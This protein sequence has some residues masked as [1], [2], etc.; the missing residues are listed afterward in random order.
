MHAASLSLPGPA[1]L[2]KSVLYSISARIGGSGLDTDCFEALRGLHGAGILGRAVAYANRQTEIPPSFIL[3]LRAHPARLLLSLVRRRYFYGAKKHFLDRV[4]ARQIVTGRYDLYHSWSGDCLRTLR[5][6]KRLGIP[7]MVEIPTWHRNKGRK[8]PART[9]SEIARDE[10]GRLSQR[11]L[12]S[13]LVTRQQVIEEY[14][15]ADILLVLSQRARETFL[16]AGIPESK[17]FDLPR[18]V[19]PDRFTPATPPDKFRAVF[20]GSLI[21][22]KGVHTLLEVW[23]RLNLK[24]AELVLV[25]SVHDE[26]KPYLEKFA[27]QNVILPG[28][29]KNT[30]DY[31]RQASLHIFPSTCEGSA[32]VTYEAAACGLPQISTRESGDVVVDGLNG[33][34]VPCN[35]P[36]ALAAAIERLY[37]NPGLMRTMGL[38]ARK[39]IVENFTWDHYRAR[40]LDACRLARARAS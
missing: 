32:K 19:D 28:F 4:T 2:P 5:Q 6:A 40:L 13:M 20:L 36:D 15:L 17:L 14:D 27:T 25:G 24:D 29:A 10:E 34:V 7:T 21:K 1:D 18:G 11:V 3:S 30:Q 39:R 38:A 35:N 26:I 12:N 37:D 31:L 33:L 23:H 8:K 9:M 22:R 16:A